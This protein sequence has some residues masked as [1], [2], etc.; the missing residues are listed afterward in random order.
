M[1]TPK[2]GSLSTGTLRPCDLIP[3]FLRAIAHLDPDAY[4]AILDTL[5]KAG[6]PIHFLTSIVSSGLDVH[7][8][9]DSDEAG[10]LL[11]DL[12]DALDALAPEG[13]YFGSHIGD[14][15]DFGF[16]PYEED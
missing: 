9:W 3:T 14:G 1:T 16:W 4:A 13:C 2:L 15:S 7:P 10:Y 11:E 12:F 8:W 6:T 5:E